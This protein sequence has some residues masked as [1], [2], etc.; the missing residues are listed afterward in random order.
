MRWRV[1]QVA[2]AAVL[3]RGDDVLASL[4]SWRGKPTSAH[5]PAWGRQGVAGLLGQCR[6]VYERVDFE[7]TGWRAR[8]QLVRLDGEPFVHAHVVVGGRDTVAHA[9]H[10]MAARCA[11]T[12]E[13]FTISAHI[14]AP[15]CRDRP[16]PLPALSGSRQT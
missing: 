1:V 9:G 11:A 13:L 8:R 4:S 14:I 6:Q 12:V 10:L 7:A 3:H 16:E 2:G 5:L 15:R